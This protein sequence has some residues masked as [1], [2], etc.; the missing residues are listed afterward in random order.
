MES[1]SAESLTFDNFK[2]K[3]PGFSEKEFSGHKKRIYSLNWN[4]TGLKLASASADNGIRVSLSF[5]F[6]S[7]TLK[8]LP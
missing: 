6:S 1:I 5:T 3:F 7:G 2:D 4:C 8:P